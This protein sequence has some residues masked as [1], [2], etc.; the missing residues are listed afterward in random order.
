MV[1]ECPRGVLGARLRIGIYAFVQLLCV[2]LRECITRAVGCLCDFPLY[3][4][5]SRIV[6]GVYI[7][8]YDVDMEEVELFNGR[9][10]YRNFDV[11]FIC[12]FCAGARFIVVLADTLVSP[13]DGRFDVIGLVSD[14]G[15]IVVKGKFYCVEDLL[16]VWL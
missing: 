15:I 6:V 14:D 10:A 4:I 2:L 1:T 3:S 16:W 13:A 8:V 7:W 9:G 11:F 12:A 5:V